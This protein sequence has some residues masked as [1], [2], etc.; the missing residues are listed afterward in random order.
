MNNSREI[1]LRWILQ[2]TFVHR[3]RLVR[4]MA[5]CRQATSHYQRWYGVTRTQELNLCSWGCYIM[6]WQHFRNSISG[7]FLWRHINIDTNPDIL[8]RAYIIVITCK[9]GTGQPR[10]GSCL[11]SYSLFV[12]LSL[13]FAKISWCGIINLCLRKYFQWPVIDI[14]AR[15]L[16]F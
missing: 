1:A 2:N 6:I 13:T 16:H 11:S 7:P 4:V 9:A 8:H 10:C 14:T 3:S 5:W 12:W 15:V